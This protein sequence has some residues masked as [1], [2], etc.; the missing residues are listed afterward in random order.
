MGTIRLVICSGH[1]QLISLFTPETSHTLPKWTKW[2]SN[3]S[4]WCVHS[5]YD[6]GFTCGMCALKL[7]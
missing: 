4:I 6:V 7:V 1:L 2:V 5:H 3:S